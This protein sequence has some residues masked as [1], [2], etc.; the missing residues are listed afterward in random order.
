MIQPQS[1]REIFPA[2]EGWGDTIPNIQKHEVYWNSQV[3]FQT[4]REE[5]HLLPAGGRGG[6]GRGRGRG[7]GANK[8]TCTTFVVF[9]GN[10]LYRVFQN[11]DGIIL[12]HRTLVKSNSDGLK[13]PEPI[14]SSFLGTLET[15]QTIIIDFGSLI[16]CRITQPHSRKKRMIFDNRISGTL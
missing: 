10:I 11:G 1:Y 7:M 5:L 12:L 2:C 3:F 8:S 13:S 9:I 15:S 6:R 16:F 4:Q 14:C